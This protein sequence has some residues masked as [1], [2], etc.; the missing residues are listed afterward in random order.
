MTMCLRGKTYCASGRNRDYAAEKPI[1]ELPN[2]QHD[3]MAERGVGLMDAII[4]RIGSSGS[5]VTN[6]PLTT[7]TADDKPAVHDVNCDFL[8]AQSGKLKDGRDE[9]TVFVIP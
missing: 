4:G 5:R 2:L 8:R 3:G 9:G 7:L 6:R 1:L